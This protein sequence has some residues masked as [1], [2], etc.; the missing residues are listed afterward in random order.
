[1]GLLKGPF[2]FIFGNT[3]TTITGPIGCGKSTLLTMIKASLTNS[4]PGSGSSW[5]SW[6]IKPG[7]PSYF[8]ATWELD[9]HTLEI[10]KPLADNKAFKD[11]DLPRI[12]VLST[13]GEV[14]EDAY[15]AKAA[16]DLLL[17]MLPVSPKVIDSHLII[18]QDQITYPA[19]AT[20]AKF[21]ETI[22]VLTRVNEMEISRTR[23]RE[24][25]GAYAVPEVSN[26]E[27]SFQSDVDLITAEILET[28]N[29][30]TS[31]TSTLDEIDTTAVSNEI[32]LLQEAESNAATRQQLT[33][34][35]E[36][37]HNQK[38]VMQNRLTQMES[39]ES[40]LRKEW[41]QSSK[42][43]I[44]AEESIATYTYK[45]S[46]WEDHVEL[47]DEL[48]ALNQGKDALG[49]P[50]APDEPE[51]NIDTINN[52]QAKADGAGALLL[53]TKKK[54]ELAE[55]GC[56][57][58]C[59][60]RTDEVD[61]DVLVEEEQAFQHLVNQV[62]ELLIA[63]KAKRQEYV[64]Y[65]LE[66]ERHLAAL[67]RMDDRIQSCQDRLDKLDSP[68]EMAA[69]SLEMWKSI[70]ET[71]H[72]LSTSLET[73]TRNITDSK[74]RLEVYD[75]G[76]TSSEATLNTIAGGAVDSVRLKVLLSQQVRIDELKEE[77]ATLTGVVASKTSEL[78][79]ANE[80]LG[81]LKKRAASAEPIKKYRSILEKAID[82]LH[83][84]NLPK[85]V[86]AQYL[87]EI[88]I[89]LDEYLTMVDADFSAWIDKDLQFM[90]KKTDGLE[91]RANRLSGGQKQQASISYLLAVND[92]FASSLGVLALDEPTGSMQ[93]EN[94]K[95]VAETFSQL[96]T[97][98]KQ[99]DRQFI[100]I[101][102]SETLASY[103]EVQID[104]KEYT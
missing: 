56:C 91:H 95:D 24:S 36:S 76:I 38:A 17:K 61:K 19:S 9:N 59:G 64:E 26:E 75:T 20:P 72:N 79:R 8:T 50:Q 74:F 44:H 78:K 93:E 90:V 33:A 86:S 63:V 5:V 25:L 104:L 82:V 84:N 47:T 89:K 102:H 70:I 88:N 96:V 34:E 54:L 28:E 73:L 77:R 3:L 4:I 35:I 55:L 100:V 42:L 14:L 48:E 40:S 87:A 101:T 98:G 43:A 39:T 103:G 51:P 71:H 16:N 97:I 13:E 65:R 11:L 58:E 10:T 15:T 92:V 21:Q 53:T 7:E 41:E 2:E 23:L 1:M 31:I 69:D 46:A 6:G 37:F 99:T 22:H 67:G 49:S 52:L 27:D 62:A 85:L 12:A 57:P 81:I 83:K 80:R 18:E 45:Q 94:A 68:E 30:I 66:E 60:Q 32:A 29:F